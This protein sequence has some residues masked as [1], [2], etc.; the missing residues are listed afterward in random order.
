MRLWVSSEDYRNDVRIGMDMIK[1]IADS[2]R[3]IRNTFKFIIGNISD[4]S[5]K[6]AV[7][8]DRLSDL[9]KWI[10]HKLYVLSEKVIEH[11]ENFEFHLVY[12]KILNFCAVDLSSIYFDISKDILYVEMKDSPK[13]R[14]VQTALSEIFN[15]LV[16]LAAP[17][18]VFT[19]EEVWRFIGK[20]GSIHTERYYGLNPI[21]RNEQIRERMEGLVDI[22]ED[23]LKAL[24]ESRRDKV[25]KSSLE[26]AITM[27]VKQSAVRKLIDELGEDV[28]RFFQVA[29]VKFED[30]EVPGMKKYNISSISVGKTSGEKCV[31]CWNYTE[32]R[33][34]DPRHPELC[35]RCTGIVAAIPE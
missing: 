23:V 19:A 18:L 10:L 35:P 24:E 22:K 4:F 26:A 33:G 8:Y 14:A 12:R 5:E 34:S 13:R 17:V 30:A 31:R 1:Q 27:H 29:S 9:D 7:P 11:Y 15:S 20:P 6:D 21:Y 2:Y 16:R 25:V 3:R 32:N 28:T